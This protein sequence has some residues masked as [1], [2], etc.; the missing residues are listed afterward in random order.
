VLK[1]VADRFF[2]PGVTVVYTLPLKVA[3]NR[4]AESWKAPI[5]RL[6]RREHRRKPH[7]WLVNRLQKL[8]CW[9]L[10][11]RFWL[12]NWQQ[13]QLKVLWSPLRGLV[14][15]NIHQIML[16]ITVAAERVGDGRQRL[17]LGNLPRFESTEGLEDG[18][19]LARLLAKRGLSGLAYAAGWVGAFRRKGAEDRQPLLCESSKWTDVTCDGEMWACIP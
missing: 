8:W 7:L 17:F 13:W 12:L 2:V 19:C 4:R 1:A 18:D 5:T 15:E 11:L 3:H 14:V 16:E 6:P 9:L 10:A